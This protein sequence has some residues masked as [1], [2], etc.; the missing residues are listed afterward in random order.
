LAA[1]AL[2]RLAKKYPS[3]F[4]CTEEE[5]EGGQEKR[6]RLVER[7]RVL[8]FRLGDF[9][10]VENHVI[11]EAGVIFM[12]TALPPGVKRQTQEFLGQTKD[13]CRIL[14]FEDLNFNWRRSQH[15]SHFH[16][17]IFNDVSDCYPTSWCPSPGHPFHIWQVDRTRQAQ[18]GKARVQAIT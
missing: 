18:V 5:R 2:R 6:V 9:F 17:M 16:R 13:G 10:R 12:Q 3:I 8:E 4:S 11:S 1:R 15:P 7:D 14:T